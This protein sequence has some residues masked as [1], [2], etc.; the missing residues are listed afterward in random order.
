MGH[1]GQRFGRQACCCLRL[2]GPGGLRGQLL[3]W[4]RRVARDLQGGG[5]EDDR[6]RGCLGVQPP[7][8]EEREGWQILGL[9][10]RRGQPGRPFG[11][12]CRTVGGAAEE[13]GYAVV[14]LFVTCKLICGRA[15][16]RQGQKP[17]FVATSSLCRGLRQVGISQCCPCVV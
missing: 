5:C 12:P 9:S 10:L 13:R 3:R 4:H 6:V 16:S 2:W 15:T 17:C 11:G 8:I 7:G 14:I 1:Q